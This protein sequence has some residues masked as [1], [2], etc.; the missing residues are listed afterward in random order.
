LIKLGRKT[1]TTKKRGKKKKRNR[2]KR[3]MRGY[4]RKYKKVRKYGKKKRGTDRIK[5]K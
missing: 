1:A 3:T 2:I 5:R 4:G